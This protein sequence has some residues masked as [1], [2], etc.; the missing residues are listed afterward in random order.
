MG[1]RSTMNALVFYGPYDVRLEKRPSEPTRWPMTNF[2]TI[3][4]PTDVILKTTSAAFELHAY[5]GHAKP[6]PGYITGHEGAGIVDQ[7]GVDVKK[8]KKGDYVVVPFTATCGHC[9]FCTHGFSSRCSNG[10]LFGSPQLDGSQAEYFRVPMADTTL[11]LAPTELGEELILMA[12]IFPTGFNG[13]RN[14]F[15]ATPKEQWSEMVVVVVGCGP[16][17]LCS[18]IAALDYKPARL[19]AVDSVPERLARAEKIGAI[20]LNFKT[21]DIKAEILK[22]TDGRGADAVIEV[23]GHPDALR[24]AYDVIREFGKISVVGLHTKDIPFSGSEA[25]NKNVHIQFGR[26]PV[27]SVFDD[28]FKSLIKNREKVQSFVD[29]IVPSLD[30]SFSDAL[31]RFEKNEVFKVVY[32]PNGLNP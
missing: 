5:R 8:F 6:S 28:A 19:Y 27:R 2:P 17:A 30:D 13:A 14:A 10:E 21:T 22:A 7:V 11:S 24:T 16:V 4:N 26:C 25:Y 18:I 12:D 20:P 9:Y 15:S 32:K 1:S 29:V 23:V 31:K 3:Q